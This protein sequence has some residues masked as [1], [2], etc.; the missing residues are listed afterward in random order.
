MRYTTGVIS[1][2]SA[3]VC[4]AAPDCAAQRQ[5]SIGSSRLRPAPAA[6]VIP[7]AEPLD[8]IPCRQ[9]MVS[10]SGY[11]KAL[12]SSKETVFVT[13]LMADTTVEELRF[14]ITYLDSSRRELHRLSRRVRASVPPGATRRIDFPSWDTQ[15]SFYYHLSP[16]PRTSAIPYSVTI[17]PDTLLVIPER[18]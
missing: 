17:T 6:S 7:S 1:L 14:T 10:F 15:R 5:N 8:T 11:D 4:C 13:N 18:Q 9:G 12:R 3:A 2:L 16:P